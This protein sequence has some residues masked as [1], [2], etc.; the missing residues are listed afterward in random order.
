[1]GGGGGVIFSTWGG[2][3]NVK[4]TKGFYILNGLYKKKNLSNGDFFF[5]LVKI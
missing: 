1:L 2:K 5:K 3:Q 4:G